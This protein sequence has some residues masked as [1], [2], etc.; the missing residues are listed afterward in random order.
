M[1]ITY[2]HEDGSWWAESHDLPGLFAGGDSLEEAKELA[3][4]VVSD[5][6]GD[7]VL[8]FEWM[9]VP[10]PFAAVVS[11]GAS[12]RLDVAGVPSPESEISPHWDTPD[13]T[14]A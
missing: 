11:E 4:Q 1:Q 7:D 10:D 5:E 14:P 12:G 6:L 2:H 3:R 8:V 9:P 13:S